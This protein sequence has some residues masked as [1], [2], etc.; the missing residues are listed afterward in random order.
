[1]T[2]MTTE[3]QYEAN[4]DFIHEYQGHFAEMDE[5]EKK[6]PVHS[7]HCQK[8][9]TFIFGK[10]LDWKDNANL[11]YLIPILKENGINNVFLQDTSDF[12]ATIVQ[13]SDFVSHFEVEGINFF[14]G[15]KADGMIIPSQSAAIFRS[16]DC[17]T[18]IFHDIEN[19]LLIG[20]H[21]GLESLIDKKKLATGAPFRDHESVV[22][23]IVRFIPLSTTNHY[24]IFIL[25][26]ISSRNF[27]YDISNPIYKDINLKIFSYLLKKYGLDAVPR[28]TAKGNI[29]LLGI[30]KC[31]FGRYGFD[32]DKV[33]SDGLDTFSDSR[34]WSHFEE[35]LHGNNG[36][37]RNCVLIIHS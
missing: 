23:E 3:E 37:E 25:A 16:A 36:L 27:I 32:S 10:P 34:L 28:S 21:A 12:N 19:D 14:R 31:Q 15:V 5:A 30:T 17:P 7:L 26:G 4:M 1:M 24:E 18:I 9:K 20:A 11:Y 33:I 29:S 22:D 8:V 2:P 13:S 6:S 35:N